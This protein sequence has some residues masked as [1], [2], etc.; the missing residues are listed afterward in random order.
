MGTH[1]DVHLHRVYTTLAPK[2]ATGGG[3]NRTGNVAI[4]P[5]LAPG[6]TTSIS[7][8]DSSRS[9]WSSGSGG[10]VG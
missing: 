9:E 4:I 7:R 2:P 3:A 8:V 5:E 1:T 6:G 10:S